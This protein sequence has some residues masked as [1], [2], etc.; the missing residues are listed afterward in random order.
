[1]DLL[2]CLLNFQAVGILHSFAEMAKHG[3][4]EF[5]QSD[6]LQM[7]EVTKSSTNI[8][9]LSE[10]TVI[11]KLKVKVLARIVV[12]LLLFSSYSKLQSSLVNF[13]L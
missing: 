2:T 5:L 1:M 9:I 3:S 4:S 6:A 11:R 7:L 13:E 8:T 12:R 10:N